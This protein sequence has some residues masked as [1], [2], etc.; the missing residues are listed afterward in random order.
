MSQVTEDF[1]LHRN[2]ASNQTPRKKR[3]ARTP[4]AGPVTVTRMANPEGMRLANEI[5]A[6]HPGRIEIVSYSE[7]VVIHD[8]PRG[9]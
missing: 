1:R 8:E 4:K 2:A 5:A 7:V 3:K 6:T 9:V